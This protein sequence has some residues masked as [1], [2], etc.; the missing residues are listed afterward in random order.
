MPPLAKASH[1]LERGASDDPRLPAGAGRSADRSIPPPG[2]AGAPSAACLL[3]QTNKWPSGRRK[4]R[5][6]ICL[7]SH[8]GFPVRRRGRRATARRASRASPPRRGRRR[9][10][11]APRPSLRRRLEGS[12]KRTTCA[13][14]S[15]LYTLPP[16]PPR[17]APPR[18]RAALSVMATAATKTSTTS[19]TS[20]R[21]SSCGY[22]LTPRV[23]GG[24]VTGHWRTSVLPREEPRTGG[25]VPGPRC[26]KLRASR[27]LCFRV[28]VSVSVCL[29][30]A[31]CFLSRSFFSACFCLFLLSWLLASIVSAKLLAVDQ[32]R[33]LAPGS[34]AFLITQLRLPV[35]L[36]VQLLLLH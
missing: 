2:F 22:R 26:E 4:L 17:S 30:I 31:L 24:C 5:R 10:A 18:A 7:A 6:D 32:V 1:G 11:V 36:L 21:P 15:A 12:R 9:S 14:L 35:L 28:S 23:L 20:T 25:G 33:T 27:T 16:A 3:A 19:S 34:L 29:A 13:L 8:P